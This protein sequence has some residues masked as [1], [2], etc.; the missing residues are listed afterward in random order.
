[1]D[2]KKLKKVLNQAGVV[3]DSK[4]AV[5]L[6]A[7]HTKKEMHSRDIKLQQY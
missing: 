4:S 3:H 7:C 6:W 1:M 5:S 2:H